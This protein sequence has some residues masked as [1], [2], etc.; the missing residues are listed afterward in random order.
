MKRVLIFLMV[1]LALAGCK[2]FKSESGVQTKEYAYEEYY[3][4]MEGRVDSLYIS[5]SVDFPV[6][7]VNE[8]ILSRVQRTIKSELFGDAYQDMEIKQ[9]IEAYTAMIKTEYR[10]NNLPLVEEQ[11]DNCRQEMLDAIFRE[12]Q[13]ITSMVMAEYKNILSYAVERY[14]FMGGAHGSNYR[15]FYNFDLETGE[16]LHEKDLFKENYEKPLTD[17]LLSNLISQNEDVQLVEDLKE[18]GYNVDEIAPN[19]NFFL[20][21]SSLVYVFNPYDIAP[22]ALGETEISITFDQL[23]D[24][25]Q[26]DRL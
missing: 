25:L 7:G 11:R 20:T 5:I 19:D 21:D 4:L 24:L 10:Q 2:C 8:E 26:S 18:F 9:A 17:L 1:V 14:V 15:I 13:I 3:A 12:E 16:L 22:Y 23:R 6:S